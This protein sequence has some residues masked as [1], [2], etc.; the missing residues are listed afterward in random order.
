MANLLKSWLFASLYIYGGYDP[1]IGILTDL[2]AFDLAYPTCEWVNVQVDNLKNAPKTFRNDSGRV[3]NRFYVIGG[4]ENASSS[5][6]DICC[7]TM[8]EDRF[9][10]T[11]IEQR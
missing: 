7:L 9:F 5:S 1:I 8:D 10:W 11:K 4:K 2:W 6:S 3:G